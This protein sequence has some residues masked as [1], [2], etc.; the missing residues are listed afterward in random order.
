MSRNRFSSV[1][2]L[3]TS[4]VYFSTY[5]IAGFGI[6]WGNNFSLHMDNK[7]NEPLVFNQLKVTVPGLDGPISGKDLQISVT[8]TDLKRT[9]IDIGA[10]FYIDILPI[11]DGMQLSA[12]YGVWEYKGSIR[13]PA[14]ISYSGNLDSPAKIDSFEII[15]ITFDNF[16]MGY[17]VKNTPYMK[18]NFDLTVRKY[19]AQFPKPLKILNLYGGG[20][21]SLIFATPALTT[22]LVEDALGNRLNTTLAESALKG[23]LFGNNDVMKAVAEEITSQL[24]TPHWGCH[25]DLGLMIKI[26]ILPVGLYVDGKYVIPFSDLDKEANITAMGFSLNTGIALTF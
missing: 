24:M 5:A 10:T 6:Q 11:L 26:P 19:I 7:I 9:M 4:A 21:L 23:S 15:P 2:F 13:Y 8:R 25:I 20:G 22:K 1:I 16:N 14:S 17:L 12:N 18:L 3:L